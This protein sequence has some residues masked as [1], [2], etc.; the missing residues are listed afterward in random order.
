MINRCLPWVFLLRDFIF[1]FMIGYSRINV[2]ILIY[3]QS[4]SKKYTRISFLKLEKVV[5]LS[6][7]FTVLNINYYIKRRRQANAKNNRGILSYFF[8]RSPIK[9]I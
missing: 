8:E 7:C 2:E 3:L 9:W 4:E 1:L 5:L 6:S